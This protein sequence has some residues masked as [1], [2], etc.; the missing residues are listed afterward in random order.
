MDKFDWFKE[1]F[2]NILSEDEQVEIFNRFC[3]ESGLEEKIYSMGEFNEIFSS[4][5]PYD[6]FHMIWFNSDDVDW[7]DKYFVV[8]VYGFKTF[9][10]PYEFIEDYLADIYD[11]MHLWEQFINIDDYIEDMYDG[12]YDLKPE[13]MDSDEFYDIVENAVYSNDHESDMIEDIKKAIG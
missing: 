5:T 13:E 6:L 8:T 10:A 11:K 1:Q 12:H 2:E 3:G 7:N 4:Y 9:S